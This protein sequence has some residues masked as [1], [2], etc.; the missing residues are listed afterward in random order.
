MNIQ[1]PTV[2]ATDSRLLTESHTQNN[3]E[4]SFDEKLKFAQAQLGFLFAPLPQ[5]DSLFNWNPGQN[6]QKNNA[7]EPLPDLIDQISKQAKLIERYRSEVKPLKGQASLPSLTFQALN[8]ATL[9]QALTVSGWLTPNLAALPAFSLAALEGKLQPS[10]NLQFLID[11]IIEKT[12]L[13]KEQGKTKL[14]LAMQPEG[15][16]DLLL[17][18][19]SSGGL[20]SINIQAQPE[21][22]K[23]L[24][25]ELAGLKK[26]LK[27]HRVNFS[28]IIIEEVGSDHV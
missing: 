6:N 12:T 8:R 17:T 18:L 2:D 10:L 21:A 26:S 7:T 24:E 23:L 1:F 25:G 28:E 13:F 15:L 3:N 11:E 22:K 20:V 19:T 4:P 14:S 5:F 9:Q 27:T 16:G